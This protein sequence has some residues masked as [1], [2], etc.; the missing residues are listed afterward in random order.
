MHLRQ[1]V[2]QVAAQRPLI[3]ACFSPKTKKK[4]SA[5]LCICLDRSGYRIKGRLASFTFVG[6]LI[7][8]P[9]RDPHTVEA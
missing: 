9:F 3:M 7:K 2:R 4:T 1:Y 5:L 8:V 6:K